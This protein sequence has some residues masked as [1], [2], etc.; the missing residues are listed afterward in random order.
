MIDGIPEQGTLT[1]YAS[2]S[3]QLNQNKVREIQEAAQDAA[4]HDEALGLQEEHLD[5]VIAT[6]REFASLTDSPASSL[7]EQA[8]QVCPVLQRNTASLTSWLV[9]AFLISFLL[10]PLPN[11]IYTGVAWPQQQFARRVL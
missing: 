9:G 8:K 3:A 2:Q 11:N 6:L 10:P 1:G 7:L 5:R 4:L